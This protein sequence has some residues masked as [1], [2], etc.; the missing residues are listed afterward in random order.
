MRLTQLTAI[1]ALAAAGCSAPYS[2]PDLAKAKDTY[3]HAQKTGSPDQFPNEFDAAKKSIAAAQSS[4]DAQ[5]SFE[6]GQDPSIPRDLSKEAL[7]RAEIADKSSAAAKATADVKAKEAELAALQ[8]EWDAR[9]ADVDEDALRAAREKAQREADEARARLAKFAD[10]KEDERG[11]II[12]LAGGIPFA[13]GK[14]DLKPQA[15]DRLKIVAETLKG[16][17]ADHPGRGPHRQHRH[18]GEEP[19][20]Q[21]G[22]GG[23]RAEVPGRRWHPRLADPLGGRRPGAAG[24]RQQDLRGPGEEPPRGSDSGEAEVV[25]TCRRGGASSEDGCAPTGTRGSEASPPRWGSTRLRLGGLPMPRGPVL[26][27]GA[28]ARRRASLRL[29]VRGGADGSGA[30]AEYSPEVVFP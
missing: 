4:Q 10:V 18:G 24:G 22:P 9:K 28:L 14:A 23:H 25:A 29:V 8:A 7:Y 1:A 12:T 21:P 30:S 3:A 16:T 19:H 20:A 13:T 15:V 26:A 11:T 5:A 6:R 27:I 2:Y 17:A